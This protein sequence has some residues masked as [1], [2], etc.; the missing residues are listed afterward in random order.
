V[1][2]AVMDKLEDASYVIAP[3]PVDP[4]VVTLTLDTFRMAFPLMSTLVTAR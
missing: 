4:V 3:I 1:F 2:V